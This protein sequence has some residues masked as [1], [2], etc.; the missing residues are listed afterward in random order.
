[1]DMLLKK[2]RFLFFTGALLF[3]PGVVYFGS[4]ITLEKQF[5]VFTDVGLVMSAMFVI[6]GLPLLL[7]AG[8]VL[9]RNRRR[10]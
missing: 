8:A 3:F 9:F 7:L 2:G 6:I 1:M 10:M 5:P 4:F